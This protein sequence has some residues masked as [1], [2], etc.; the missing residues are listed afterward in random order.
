[1]GKEGASCLKAERLCA[2][3]SAHQKVDRIILAFTVRKL[4]MQKK[5]LKMVTMRVELMTLALLVPR[6]NQPESQLDSE[7]G[8]R[9]SGRILS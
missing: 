5:L 7:S 9:E 6:S 1:M 4:K 2:E 8:N 3:N